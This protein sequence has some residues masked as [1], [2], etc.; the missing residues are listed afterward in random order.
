MKLKDILSKAINKNNK[1]VTL[2]LKKRKADARG[3]NIE[4]ILDMEIKADRDF[5]K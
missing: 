2:I 3:V 1:Q 5:L 4:R